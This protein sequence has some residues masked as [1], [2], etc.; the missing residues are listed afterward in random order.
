MIKQGSIT[1]GCVLPTLILSLFAISGIG[2]CQNSPCYTLLNATTHAV[3]VNFQYPDNL[4]P[5]GG[6]TN[7]TFSPNTQQEYC[8]DAYSA[9]AVIA[10]PN[11][12][13]E[14]N[15]RMVM[16]NTAGALPFGTYRM[17]GGPTPGPPP[18]PNSPI[19]W[20][21]SLFGQ[22][23]AS[24]VDVRLHPLSNYPGP[25][26]AVPFGATHFVL[27]ALGNECVNYQAGSRD[28]HVIITP[29]GNCPK[30]GQQSV[31]FQ[32]AGG[33]P[34]YQLLVGGGGC[35]NL[36]EAHWNQPGQ[37]IHLLPCTNG[38]ASND[39][40]AVLHNP[41]PSFPANTQYRFVSKRSGGCL[42]LRSQ[43]NVRSAQ[44]QQNICSGVANQWWTLWN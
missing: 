27:T 7:T 22:A 6:V 39:M 37:Y 19:F 38:A 3:V 20:L 9:T 24:N 42:D 44:V 28:L 16:G 18:T 11:T 17:I 32:R 12:I 2:L 21:I 34:W 14:G 33:G 5:D 43:D 10:T 13:W 30:V 23:F 36:D 15:K 35:I 4:V 26:N 40:W 8:F 1:S 41:N 31:A 29:S 25:Q